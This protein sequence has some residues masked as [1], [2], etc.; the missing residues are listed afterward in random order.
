[1]LRISSRCLILTLVLLLAAMPQAPV[2]TTGQSWAQLE[3]TANAVLKRIQQGQLVGESKTTAMQE[4]LQGTRRYLAA[5]PGDEKAWLMCANLCGEL[6]NE[7]CLDTSARAVTELNPQNVQA[8]LQWAA[9]Y[10]NQERLDRSL[11][12]LGELLQKNPTSLMY[13]NAWILTAQV[14]DPELIQPRFKKL[15]IDP[16][17]P[18]API[19]FLTAMQKNDPWKAVEFGE[20]TMEWSPDHPDVR[21]IVARGLRGTNRFADAAAVLTTLPDEILNRPEIAYLHSDCLYADHHFQK[22]YDIMSAIDLDAIEGKPGLARRLK[23]M[24]PLREQALETWQRER[25]L[26]ALQS[27][28]TMNPL[29]RL[30]IN[31]KPVELELFADEAPNTVAAFLAT[32]RRGDYEGLAFGDIHTGFRSMIDAPAQSTSFTLP[33]EIG[34]EKSRH[35]FSGTVSMQVEHPSDLSKINSQWSLYHFPAPH[36][37][38]KRNVF[39][40]V[41]SG[42]ETVRNMRQGDVLES[43]EIIRAPAVAVDP[44]VIDRDGKRRKM[45][46]VMKGLNDDSNSGQDDTRP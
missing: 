40:R 35:F 31:G 20:A 32:T 45:S 39:G 44:I 28:S 15:M 27:N 3:E 9:Y 37:N 22:A 4:L 26:Q 6:G 33:S 36:L 12:V 16:A 21:V 25:E 24:L 14:H 29:V 18:E 43:I 17:S 23:F 46:E 42:L 5:N 7:E 38:D 1:M 2:E 30:T 34:I 8:G 10:T 11:E 13:W 41:T 19:A